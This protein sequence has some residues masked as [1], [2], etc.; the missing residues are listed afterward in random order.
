MYGDDEMSTQ[1]SVDAEL[2]SAID[3]DQLK[4]LRKRDNLEYLFFM[5][6]WTMYSSLLKFDRTN[7]K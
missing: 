6:I 1:K 2:V 3:E 7:L 5:Q 4:Q